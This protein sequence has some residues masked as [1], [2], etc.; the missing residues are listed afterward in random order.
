MKVI[1]CTAIIL[2]KN[3]FIFCTRYM[4]GDYVVDIHMYIQRVKRTIFI[5]NVFLTNKTLTL[6]ISK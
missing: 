6:K 2:K 5:L 3:N 4:L 1:L